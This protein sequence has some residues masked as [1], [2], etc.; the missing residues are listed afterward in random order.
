M[1]VPMESTVPTP[2]N[3]TR[4]PLGYVRHWLVAGPH[5]TPYEGPPGEENVLR[6]EALDPGRAE[7]PRNAAIG[8]PGPFGQPWRFHYPGE[9][10]F[11]EQTSFYFRLTLVDIYAFTEIESPREANLDALLWV[12]GGADL[13]VNDVHL[14]RFSPTRYMYPDAEAVVLPLRRGV[15]TLCVRLQCLG[16][17]DT[18]IL[19]GLQLEHAGDDFSTRLPGMDDTR[20]PITTAANWLDGVRTEGRDTL[21]SA[22]PAP[23]DAQA[24]ISGKPAFPW[25]AGQTR[26]SLN[27]A[28][29]FQLSVA[30]SASG[31]LLKRSLE[32]PA[33]RT[34]SCAPPAETDFQRA[35]LEHIA[36][37]VDNAG[38]A[39]LRGV[40]SIPPLTARRLLG[41]THADDDAA[42][43]SAIRCVDNRE[44]CADFGLAMLFRFHLLGLASPRESAEIKRAALAFRY[45]SDEPGTD[46]MCFW[47]ENHSLL[48]HGCQRIAGTIFPDETF[49]NSGLTGVQQAALALERCRKWLDH[50][51]PRGFEE[52][53][54]GVYMPI[55]VT[56]LLNLVDYSGDAEVS[57]RAAGLIDRIY[58][59]L[60]THA[61]QGVTIGPQGRVYRDVLYPEQSGTQTLLS[62]ATREALSN[63][64]EERPP[65]SA[66]RI[67][68]WVVFVASSPTY[69]PPKELADLMRHPVTKR[70]RQ[71]DVEIVLHKTT[72]YLL[73]SLA[74]PA[75]FLD[76]KDRPGGLQPGWGGYQ[77]HV[78]QATLAPGCH[79]FVN[80]PG[81]SF[82]ESKSRPGYWYGNGVLPRLI[83]HEG[84]LQAIYS[85]P[86]GTKPYPRRTTAEWFW[87]IGGCAVPFDRHPIPFTHAHWPA[88]AFDRQEVRG[89][90]AF[91]QKNSGYIA[92]W[93]SEEMQPHDD[94]LTG[95][96]LRAWAHCCAWMAICG[97]SEENGA[98]ESFIDSCLARN[99]SFDPQTLALR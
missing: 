39:P 83:Q 68:D 90:W 34:P 3:F 94:V 76:E 93:C 49:T 40:H 99:P 71:A 91:G 50:V 69:R 24:V 55:T 31:Q 6:R 1:N 98:F 97:C 86:D 52:F 62:F 56:A 72:A 28:R 59:D 19:F 88:D 8:S 18:R 2:Q 77:Q 44:D 61:F 58:R 67:G 64:G 22:H 85:I 10:F 7:P 73:T 35:H 36:A 63:I 82:D 26:L 80:H 78:W 33:N 16:V 48:F 70:Y 25:P 29:P 5:E 13:W 27:A 11:V 79:V 81:C 95:R 4:H 20:G 42:F 15:N 30:V 92:L 14:T 74:I 37:L 45:W 65:G 47:S 54:S 43:A 60:A 96:E 46:A 9:N 32:I 87:P 51:E 38:A 21:V 89:H 12:A 53:L 41:R 66:Q 17:R 23:P 75:S 57:R 84:M